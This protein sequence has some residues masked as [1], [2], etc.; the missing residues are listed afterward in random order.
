MATG[1]KLMAAVQYMV[2]D[3]RRGGKLS[4]PRMSQ[5]LR[6]WRRLVPLKSRRPLPW[7]VVCYLAVRL[8]IEYGFEIAIYWLVLVDTYMR[9]GECSLLQSRQVL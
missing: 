7:P 3:Y 2:A 4:L 1:L 8:A 5:A 9:P 6:G